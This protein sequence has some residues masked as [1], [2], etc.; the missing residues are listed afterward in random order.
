[1]AFLQEEFCFWKISFSFFFNRNSCLFLLKLKHCNRGT[2]TVVHTLLDIDF[3]P[4]VIPL[5]RAVFVLD[6]S[7][8]FVYITNIF[9][10]CQILQSD[11]KGSFLLEG[12]PHFMIKEFFLYTLQGKQNYSLV[13]L[14]VCVVFVFLFVV[15]II[16]WDSASLSIKRDFSFC[17]MSSFQTCKFNWIQLWVTL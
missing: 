7:C 11:R 1:M 13:S 5:M 17:N 14:C 4:I 9:V 8:S 2:T 6:F 3:L 12:P 16:C 15:A 10:G